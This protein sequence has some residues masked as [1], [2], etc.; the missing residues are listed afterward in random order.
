MY[1]E[2]YFLK[3]E[4]HFFDQ[5][6]FKN[7]YIIENAKVDYGF[8]GT[9]KY[10]DEGNIINAVLFCHNFEGNYSK[11]SDFN[12]LTDRDKVFDK[13]EYFFISI[14]S[15]GFPE[16]CSPSTS[17]LNHNFPNYEIED[18]VEFQRRL[19]KE[20]FPN[21]KKLNGIFGFSI[22]GFI[23]LAWSIYYPDDMDYIILL[24]SS[25][26]SQGHRYVF[27][28]LA[29]R[30]IGQSS[31]YALDIYDE[32]IAKVLIFIS[33]IHYLMS[34]SKDYLNNLPIF[35]IDLSIDAFAE[36]ILFIDVYDIK[37]C[38]D[39]IMSYN[40]EDELDKIKCKLLI[41][42]ADYTNY[43]V[44]KYDSV[45]LHEAVEGSKYLSIDMGDDLDITDH[46]YKV[47]RDIK[48]FVDSI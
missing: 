31:Q 34:F 1:E 6:E 11:I 32:S 43:Y 30:I 47:E 26:K 9:P 40:L 17:G 38:N 35:D 23:A 20:K 37:F 4:Q 12:A 27:A 19:L 18:L 29:N 24:N 41:I 21:I 5:F 8:F 2:K 42:A 46:L 33:Q 28:C 3:N 25:F 14:T 7:G 10:D 44:S 22:G 16:S 13:D 39:F 48:D 45:P 36:E 15:L